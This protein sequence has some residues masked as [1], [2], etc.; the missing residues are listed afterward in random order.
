MRGS[1][2]LTKLRRRAESQQTSPAP[3]QDTDF[4]LE[5][6]LLLLLLVGR[7]DTCAMGDRA[8]SR[9]ITSFTLPS[10]MEQ[11]S[12]KSVPTD[13]VLSSATCF[14][15]FAT[16]FEPAFRNRSSAGTAYQPSR[17]VGSAPFFSR[18]STTSSCRLRSS[19]GFPLARPI[20]PFRA[21]SCSAVAPVSLSSEFTA[22]AKLLQPESKTSR[23]MSKFRTASLT[24][25]RSQS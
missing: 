13:L 7:A 4:I 12:P 23:D 20:P 22:F 10:A 2:R 3:A 6:L 25:C 14:S 8:S 18:K 15:A 17:L 9:A 5:L 24:T 21:A 19:F 1:A 16:C 11:K